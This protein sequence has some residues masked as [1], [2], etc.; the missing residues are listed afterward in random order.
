QEQ[1]RLVEPRRI[2]S[3]RNSPRE[4]RAS[5]SRTPSLLHIV[6]EDG[7]DCEIF[8]ELV[9]LAGRVPPQIRIL[10]IHL[11][12]SRPD[13]MLDFHLAI[14]LSSLHPRPDGMNPHHYRAIKIVLKENENVLYTRY[15]YKIASPAQSE[16]V[17]EKLRKLNQGKDERKLSV[18]EKCSLA[19]MLNSTEKLVSKALLGLH[20][21]KHVLIT[22]RGK[23]EGQFAQVLSNTLV[24]PPGFDILGPINSNEESSSTLSMYGDGKVVSKA[25]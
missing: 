7:K 22:G 15:A 12:A 9:E 24:Q 2:R 5:A 14:V 1:R 23:M 10:E 18:P 6:L 20:G 17:G 4:T 13:E 21:F 3:T 11:D 25:Y 19:Y 8:T 16:W